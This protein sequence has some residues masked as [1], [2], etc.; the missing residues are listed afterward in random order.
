[1]M[2]NVG[3]I[4]YNNI[5]IQQGFSIINSM[6]KLLKSN[7]FAVGLVVIIYFVI[8]FYK[9]YLT[10][11]IPT[12][13]PQNNIA[14]YSTESA[15]HYRYAEKIATGEGIP[16][17][18]YRAQWP[19]G[20]NVYDNLTIGMEFVS[21]YL[22][23]FYLLFNNTITFHNFLIYFICFFSSLSIFALYLNS[24][25]ICN[26]KYAGILS[27]CV[28][29]VTPASFI[30]T[31]GNFI[32]EDFTLPFIFFS[33]FFFLKMIRE[34]KI[35]YSILSSIFLLIGL[36]T[37]HFTQF[38][39]IAFA[40]TVI[41]SYFISLYDEIT[42]KNIVIFILIIFVASLIFPILR[43]K[44]FYFSIPMLLLYSLIAINILNKKYNFKGVKIILLFICLFSI[45]FIIV[46]FI[47]KGYSAYSHVILLPYYKLIYLFKK[48]DEPSL[49]P[50]DVRLFWGDSFDTPSLQ[51]TFLFFSI[52]L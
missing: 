3:V 28:Y 48:P 31:T 24:S 35:L 33:L 43:H 46:S 2:N 36:L 25:Y 45:I 20:L 16:E 19:E 18:D 1:M 49:L 8:S 41:F 9:I 23:R 38:Y 10:K 27:V 4:N 37:W 13:D 7:W 15:F 30:R 22:Y 29:V 44:M 32:R 42:T 40:I 39:L 17:I 51:D 5:E 34:K 47:F 26:N 52:F 21:G 11:K 14:F 12:Y 50:F 6:K